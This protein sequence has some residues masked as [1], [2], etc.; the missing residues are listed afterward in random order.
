MLKKKQVAEGYVQWR[1]FDKAQNK[2]TN[3]YVV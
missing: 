3:Q 1:H 2:Q